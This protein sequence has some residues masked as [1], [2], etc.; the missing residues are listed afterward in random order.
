MRPS[1]TLDGFRPDLHV[2]VHGPRIAMVGGT[3]DAHV[4]VAE[5]WPATGFI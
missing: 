1:A 4:R 3:L 5:G 2:E